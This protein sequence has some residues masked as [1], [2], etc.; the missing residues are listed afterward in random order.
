MLR[1]IHFLRKPAARSFSIERLF[2]DVR[3][4]LPSDIDCSVR[5]SHF[6]SLGFFR[7]LYNAL[8]AGWRRGQVNHVTGDVHFLA[9]GLP[10]NR[11]ILTVHDC[12]NLHRLT[13]WRLTVLRFFWFTWPLRCVRIVTTISEA[14]RQELIKLAGAP[15]EKVRVVYNCVSPEFSGH[16]K[17]FNAERP[18]ILMLG[19]A[20]NKNLER[21]AEALAGITCSVEIIGRPSP[22][23]SAVF[24]QHGVELITRGSVT[25]EQIVDAY[26]RCDFLLFASTHEGF[27]LPIIEAQAV[28]RPVVTSK[29][30]SMAEV[31]ADSACLVDP[32]DVRSIRAGIQRVIGDPVYRAELVRLGFENQSRFSA[33]AVAAQYAA[34][35]REIAGARISQ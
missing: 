25:N 29:C 26:R 6:V 19:T 4:A 7:R 34:L 2:T 20:P 11:T 12:G 22:A 23:Q 14:T 13:G 9:M 21:M 10:R 27:G 24:A 30:S 31:A 1:V 32:F 35:Y 18:L 28:G 8:E 15:P 33:A 16:P 5:V 17:A 3:A